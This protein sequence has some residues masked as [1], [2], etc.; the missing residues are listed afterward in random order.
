MGALTL[1]GGRL[2][3][4]AAGGRQKQAATLLVRGIRR[5]D[6]ILRRLHAVREFSDEPECLLRISAARAPANVRL[7]EGIYV[8]R[9]NQILELH[10]WNEHLPHLLSAARGLGLACS[11][12]RQLAASLSELVEQLDANPSFCAVVALRARTALVPKSRLPKLH[13][14]A[15]GFGFQPAAALGRKTARGRLHRLFDSLL[16]GALGCAFNPAALRR[17]GLRRQPCDLW[18]SRHAL[19]AIYA[20][21][22]AGRHSPKRNSYRPPAIPEPEIRVLPHF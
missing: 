11:W 21:G 7:A 6:A 9:G 14:V 15:R 20:N 3:A 10:L 4:R 13:R 12:R 19:E 22:R 17:N 1:C 18:I 16:L 5:L 8:L 2:S